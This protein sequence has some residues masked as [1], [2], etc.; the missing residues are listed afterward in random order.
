MKA[1]TFKEM[2]G[3]TYE[4]SLASVAS[5]EPDVRRQFVAKFRLG[6]QTE[7]I[8]RDHGI[9]VFVSENWREALVEYNHGDV[10]GTMGVAS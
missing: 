8:I 2:E 3:Y 9:T 7:Y 5:V 1:V 10:A 4:I 6:Y